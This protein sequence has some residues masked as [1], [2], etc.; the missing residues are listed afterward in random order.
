MNKK[1][2]LKQYNT[3]G[4]A[5]NARE[6][7][8]VRSISRL[9]KKLKDNNLAVFILGGGSNI[10]LTQDVE[11]LVLKN[12]LRGKSIVSQDAEGVKVAVRSGENWHQF[13]L[14]SLENNLAGI[15]NLSLIP[16]TLGAAPIQNIGAYGVELKDIFEGL[17]AMNLETG[18][19][20]FFKKE[21]CHFGYRDSIFKREL[22]GKY[23]ITKIFLRL[24]DA[25]KAKVSVEYGAIRQILEEKKIDNPTVKDVSNAVIEIRQSKLP[26]PKKLGN[27]GSFFK[28]PVISK[29]HF[30]SVQQNFPEI[31]F[32][33]LPDGTV[34]IPA[35]WLIERAGWKGK[36]VGNTGSH[37]RQALV[38]VNYGGAT[39]AEIKALSDEIIASVKGKYGIELEREVN[40]W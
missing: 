29:T 15:E 40:I 13:V 2:S 26:D 8:S 20:R 38:L 23:F 3:F 35:G 12:E 28:N 32:Y 9:R 10:L 25:S 18:E 39:G 27:S 37:A 1:N 31:V 30:L 21:E 17:E 22:K 4:L 34:K 11:G 24:Q 5:A 6:I 36:R 33:D 7:Y 14:W 16:G 19:I